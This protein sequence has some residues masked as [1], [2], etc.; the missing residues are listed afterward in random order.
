MAKKF[1]KNTSLLHYC[2]VMEYQFRLLVNADEEPVE[3]RRL[4]PDI[5]ED[6]TVRLPSSTSV[7]AIKGA[8]SATANLQEWRSSSGNVFSAIDKNGGLFVGSMSD[9]EA[10]KG[11]LYY[12]TTTNKLVFKDYDGKINNLY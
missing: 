2:D 10:V 11:T 3:D 6:M 8:A 4:M 5:V 7:F 12:S 1:G 9:A